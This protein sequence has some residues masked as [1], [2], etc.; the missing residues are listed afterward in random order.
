MISNLIRT[1]PGDSYVVDFC[2][3]SQYTV[4]QAEV[5]QMR[6][7]ALWAKIIECAERKKWLKDKPRDSRYDSFGDAGMGIITRRPGEAKNP[8][9]MS[10]EEIGTRLF[11]FDCLCRKGYRK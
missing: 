7:R 2:D 3:G 6:D 11:Y 4:T 9:D 5:K 8:S 10:V 1:A